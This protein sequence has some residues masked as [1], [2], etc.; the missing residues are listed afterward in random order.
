MS[1]EGKGLRGERV[2]LD[3]WIRKTNFSGED[4]RNRVLGVVEEE[5]CCSQ[6]WEGVG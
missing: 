5:G 6:D 2:S 1:L 3:E 4:W